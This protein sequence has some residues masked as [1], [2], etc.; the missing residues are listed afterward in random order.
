MPRLSRR[1]VAPAAAVAVV[2]IWW[3]AVRGRPERPVYPIP[4]EG[5]VRITAEVLNASGVDGLARAATE[6]LREQGIDVVYYGNASF[7]T[8]AVTR[9]LARQGDTAAAEAVRDALRVGEVADEPDA[10][11]LLGVSV[12]LGRDA[13]ALLGFGP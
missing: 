4:G 3:L 8:L 12:Y 11:L 1:W 9:V 10:R 2:G 5:R 7:D 6:R 13:A